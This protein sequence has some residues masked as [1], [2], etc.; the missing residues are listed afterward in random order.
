MVRL[1]GKKK[2]K[3]SVSNTELANILE[4]LKNSA[5]KIVEL[6]KM[7]CDDSVKSEE[8]EK[9]LISSIIADEKKVDRLRE[10][11]IE[12]LY[13]KKGFLPKFVANDNLFII[14]RL[15]AVEDDMEIVA[16][17]CNLYQYKIPD[18]LKPDFIRLADE[19][20]DVV[21]KLVNAV[22][23]LYQDFSKA[24]KATDEI[25][26]ERRDAREVQWELMKQ[27]HALDVDPKSTF[28]LQ[29]LIRILMKVV[30]KSE[31][32]S[33]ILYSMAIKYMVLD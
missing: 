29:A 13:T 7:I 9:E 27:L 31:E 12:K 10:S 32:F 15:D 11:F 26:T 19:A 17:Y 6:I 24:K 16:R 23:L 25:Q 8:K 2:A 4:T 28:M 20:E 18:P 30:D 33:D 5:N 1:K 22:T 21:K 3:W 14:E